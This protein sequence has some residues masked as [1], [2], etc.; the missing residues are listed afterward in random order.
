M[1]PAARILAAPRYAVSDDVRL[2]AL[3]FVSGLVVFGTLLA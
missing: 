3:T 2:F 1:K